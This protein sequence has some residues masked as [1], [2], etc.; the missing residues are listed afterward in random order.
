MISLLTSFGRGGIHN[1]RLSHFHR[2]A[3]VMPMAKD[4]LPKDRPNQNLSTGKYLWLPCMTQMKSQTEKKQKRG[5]PTLPL[6]SKRTVEWG[7]LSLHLMISLRR[8]EEN[9]NNTMNRNK[10][11]LVQPEKS[12]EFTP[13]SKVTKHLHGR[14]HGPIFISQLDHQRIPI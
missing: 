10:E 13:N 4:K 2:G 3:D 7:S 14:I 1:L 6:V 11:Q 5:L 8:I 9:A 12:V